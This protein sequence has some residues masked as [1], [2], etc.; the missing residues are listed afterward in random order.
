VRREHSDA[1]D[2]LE[3]ARSGS[4]ALTQIRRRITELKNFSQSRYVFLTGGVVS[5]S[6]ASG[7]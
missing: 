6:D 5:H 7:S 4:A 3:W 2:P 1:G